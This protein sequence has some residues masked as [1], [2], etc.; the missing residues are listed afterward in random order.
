MKALKKAQ[1]IKDLPGMQVR[2]GTTPSLALPVHPWP[3]HWHGPTR[4]V[5][6]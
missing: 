1:Y 4:R 3:V 6:L 5:L 2:W